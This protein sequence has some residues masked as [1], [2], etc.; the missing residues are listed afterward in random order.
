MIMCCPVGVQ[1][2]AICTAVCLSTHISWQEAPLSQTDCA[3]HCQLKFCQL[4]HSST[5]IAFERL[6]GGNGLEGDS[7]SSELPPF[8]R[9][10]HFL[11]VVCSICTVSEILP[12][13][14]CT[15]L[16]VTWRTPLYLK[17]LLK[18]WATC[19]FQFVCKPIVFSEMCEMERFQ[20]VEVTFKDTKGHR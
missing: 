20:T 7:R 6:S 8:D 2:S 17:R 18:L 11:L 10:Y 13:L 9:P 4:L 15:W 1:S 12:H 5:K 19:A 14:Q 3:M 16:A